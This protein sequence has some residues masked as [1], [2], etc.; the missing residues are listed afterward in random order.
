MNIQ[1]ITPVIKR[2]AV[3]LSND[4]DLVANEMKNYLLTE[5]IG[6]QESSLV[7][8]PITHLDPS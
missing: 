5:S 4:S 2:F 7:T 6:V 1:S 3:S 8:N